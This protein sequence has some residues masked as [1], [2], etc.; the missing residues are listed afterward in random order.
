MKKLYLT[1]ED[2]KQQTRIVIKQLVRD[3]FI[4]DYVVGLT[5]GGLVPALYI[6]HYFKIP[7]HTL[8]VSLRDNPDTESNG[9][10]AEDAYGFSEEPKNI[11]IVDDIND[12]G[13]TMNWIMED[14]SSSCIS[15]DPK[16]DQVWGSNVRFATLYD[17]LSSKCK[18]KMSYSA[19]EINKA[20][21][22]VWVAFPWEEFA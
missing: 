18:V 4:P 3:N 12:S 7:M 2:I 20:E 22:D 11:L 10:M 15:S 6:S 13:A 8:K 17:N 16:W 21:E 14:W 5:R 1:D 19:V 9:W